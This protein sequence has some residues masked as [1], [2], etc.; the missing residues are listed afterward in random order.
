MQGKA[1]VTQRF[2]HLL[3]DQGDHH[4]LGGAALQ[5]PQISGRFDAKGARLAPKNGQLAEGSPLV[6]ARQMVITNRQHEAHRPCAL[7]PP[8]I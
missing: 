2:D 4:A 8:A 5:L 6:V 1:A 7:A 3:V